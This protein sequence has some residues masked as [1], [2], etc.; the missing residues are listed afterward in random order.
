MGSIANVTDVAC[1]DCGVCEASERM[2]KLL[3]AIG[4]VIVTA[5][6]V[7]GILQARDSDRAT[8][9]PPQPLSLA[10][11]S[12]PVAG[13]PPELAA[14]HRRVNELHDG[15]AQALDAQLRALRGHP[16]VVNLWASWCDPCRYELPFFQRQALERGAE[17]A[18]LGVNSG[19]NADDARKLSERFPMPYPSFE[20]PR[21]AIAG[22]YGAPGLPATAFYDARGELVLVHQGVFPTEAKLSAA[23]ERYALR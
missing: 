3:V 10:E 16:V 20:D 21:Q 14:L 8:S 19:D 22:R 23:I 5:A 9:A 2:R 1:R 4:A 11:V 12:R 13:A 6:V 7:I 15:G 17:V 18:F